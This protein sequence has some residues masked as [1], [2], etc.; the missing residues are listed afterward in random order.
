M[1][2]VNFASQHCDP[3]IA[4]EEPEILGMVRVSEGETAGS[5][6][7]LI[8]KPAG[9]SIVGSKKKPDKKIQKTTK[10]KKPTKSITKKI[11][12]ESGDFI[13]YD[14]RDLLS[15]MTPEEIAQYEADFGTLPKSSKRVRMKVK[16]EEKAN[17]EIEELKTILE[18]EEYA[19]LKGTT[20]VWGDDSEF[21]KEFSGPPGTEALATAGDVVEYDEL[22]MLAIMTPEEI[23][24]YEKE[25][26]PLSK[27]SKRVQ[28][29]ATEDAQVDFTANELKTVLTPEEYAKLHDSQISGNE[30][31]SA[32]FGRFSRPSVVGWLKDLKEAEGTPIRGATY[33]RAIAGAT[34]VDDTGVVL[35]CPKDFIKNVFVDYAK[36]VAVVGNGKFLAAKPKNFKEIKDK[37]LIEMEIISKV[38]KGRGD[39]III[40]V[41]VGISEEFSTCTHVVHAC[42]EQLKDGVRGDPTANPLDRRAPRRVVHCDA[43]SVS[44]LIHDEEIEAETAF[45]P[46]EISIVADRRNGHDFLEGSFLGRSDLVDNP[47]TNAYREINGAGDGFEGWTV[48]RYDQW[49][50]VQ[51]DERFPKGPLPSLH[52]GNTAGVYYLPADPNR[53][54]MGRDDVRP[55]LLEGQ[56]APEELAIQENGVIYTVNLDSDLSTGIFLDQRSQRAWLTR[57]CNKN[58]R[59][60]N[61]FAHCGAFSVAAATAGASTV[62]LDLNKKWL[63]RVRPQME[64]NGVTDFE[65]RHDCIYGDCFDWL[66]RLT[67]RGEMFDIVILDPP[68][69]SI[70]RKKKRWSVKNDMDELVALAAPLVKPGGLL[71][72]TTNNAS[73]HP[74]KFA[75]MCMKGLEEVELED[76]KLERVVPMPNDFPSIGPSNVKNLVWR[77]PE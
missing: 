15:V 52:D 71:W 12:V 57:N 38:R 26:G 29:T 25:N 63:D 72:T 55:Q 4:A 3:A 34:E 30:P 19:A 11:Q 28:V 65:E 48:D 47:Y 59:V 64:L 20:G 46:D 36:Y 66:T 51:H 16:E 53:G 42:Q 75:K 49:L 62:S 9:W 5:Y 31:E 32:T 18:P 58:T 73:I 33:W 1:G 39:D 21:A 45:W 50:L 61:C 77:M 27:S 41:G 44:S 40:T 60:L 6:A 13:E 43:L 56:P 23:A 14:E 35:L 24:Q 74:I 7:Y 70:G 22:D 76:A 10:G 69:A 54:N 37:G 67:K 2:L 17:F 8:N 68:S